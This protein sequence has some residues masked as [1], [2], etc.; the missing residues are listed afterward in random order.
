[1]SNKLRSMQVFVSA[2]RSD[3]FASA[4]QALGMSAVMVGKHVGA[5]E[6]QLG[7]RLIERTT[8]KQTL[9]EIGA[10]YLDRCEDVLA[11]VAAADRVAEQLRA[12]PQGSL[13]ISAP[14][15]YGVQRLTQVIAAYCATHPQVRIELT[16]N[17]SVVDMAEEGIDVAVRSG[18][19][20]D[21]DLIARP[22]A[23]L[24]MLSAASPAYLARHGAPCQPD[25]LAAH[26]LLVFAGWGSQHCLRYSRHDT[27]I[28]VTVEGNFVCNH[29]HALVAA[30]LAGMGVVV[31]SDALI[32][33]YL[34]T[35][36]L[37]ALLPEWQLPSRPMHIVRRPEA[38]PSAKVRSFVDFVLA[39]LG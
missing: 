1:M 34:L 22:L 4:A 12:V 30:A 13:R 8:R 19:L 27:T 25:Q 11:S 35:G 5:L 6:R 31:Q 15:V 14:V 29:G 9:T 39:R 32:E 16:L 3:S 36:E 33:P 17:N 10:S 20:A 24:R 37:V 2:A 18:V 7:A 38:R 23:P 28:A 26:N 21:T